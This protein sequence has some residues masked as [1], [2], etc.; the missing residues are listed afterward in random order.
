MSSETNVGRSWAK[1]RQVIIAAADNAAAGALLR[2]RLGVGTGFVDP[3]LETIDMDDTTIPVGNGSF[4]EI[5][6]PRDSSTSLGRWL[7]KAGGSG[8]YMLA[9]QHSDVVGVRRRAREMGIAEVLADVV[10]GYELA[11]FSP[12]EL[13]LI[14]EVDGIPDPAVW[15]WDH[16]DVQTQPDAAVNDIVGVEVA[17]K[18]PDT[19]AAVW[20]KLLDLEP[21]RDTTGEPRRTVRQFRRW[22]GQTEDDVNHAAPGAR[23][24][25]CRGVAARTA[26]QLCIAVRMSDNAA[27]DADTATRVESMVEGAMASLHADGTPMLNLADLIRRRAAATPGALA[28]RDATGDTTYEELDRRSNQVAAWLAR[29]GVQRGD[30]VALWCGNSTVVFEVLFGAAKVG[31][32]T[33]IVN[34]RLSGAEVAVILA[35]AEPS[36]VIVDRA[37]RSIVD[38]AFIESVGCN[39]VTF[40]TGEFESLRDAL[41]TI[42]SGVCPEP[43]ATTLVLYSSGTT[44]V[45]KGIE[46]TGRNL[47][48]AMTF[49][50]R[51]IELDERSVCAAPV[52][53][54]HIGG[55][56]L[57]LSAVLNGA[58]LLLNF[59]TGTE[60]ILAGLL[61]Q[62]VTHVAMVPTVLE[63]LLELPAARSADW[64]CLKYLLYGAAVMPLPVLRDATALIGCRFLQ[65]YG[66]T[67]SAGLISVLLPEHHHQLATETEQSLLARLRSVG[68]PVPGLRVRVVDPVTLEAVPAGQHGEV[69]VAGPNVMNG[70]WRQPALTHETILPGGWL[71]TGDGGSFSADGFLVLHDRIKD[72]IITGGENVF[73]IEV[74]RVLLA[75]PD[76]VEAATVG[77]PSAKW[78]ES[79][80]A[81]VVRRESGSVTEAALIGWMR[82]RLAHFKCPVG[83]RFVDALPR[84]VLGKV[85]KNAVRDDLARYLASRSA[86]STGTAAQTVDE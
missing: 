69:Q 55:I 20:N 34:N 45:P 50:T 18:D 33:V 42:D 78:G 81:V 76:I 30:R 35:D 73:S 25:A 9:I 82:E 15:Y 7:A 46:L 83:V 24:A 40:G 2:S 47:S 80:F 3:G 21:R 58:C 57:S 68:R 28:V 1:L 79:P 60:Q 77:I 51:G 54:F 53:L 44:G 32:I 61:E 12:W 10:Q 59:G 5:I 84:T 62:K 52:P 75:H 31:A 14:I 38:S 67:E 27:M 29:S 48:A 26:G 22:R 36:V 37:T 71:R 4:L 17:V 63:R 39:V 64:T 19:V 66:M 11:Q 23:P 41:E 13:G 49:L 86:D 72:M 56:D 6:S 8:G 43:D 85:R 16:L 70:Y 74:D 65:S